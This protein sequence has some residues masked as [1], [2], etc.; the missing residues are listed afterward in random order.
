Y[1]VLGRGLR[2]HVLRQL[3]RVLHEEGRRRSDGIAPS[4]VRFRR[5]A[6]SP[7]RDS[8]RDQRLVVVVD[9]DARGRKDAAVVGTTG[10]RTVFVDRAV[11]VDQH[12]AMPA[13]VVAE[14]YMAA[15]KGESGE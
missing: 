11:I 14:T 1:G 8:F 2:R 12:R 10:P 13:F 15:W 4:P 3:V 5:E 9:V 6:E 7:A